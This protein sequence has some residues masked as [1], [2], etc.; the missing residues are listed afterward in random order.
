[1]SNLKT[2]TRST[3]SAKEGSNT[4]NTR[5]TSNTN[6]TSN[7]S[8]TSNTNNTNNTKDD[9]LVVP[10]PSSPSI[11]PKRK[12][13]NVT[14]GSTMMTTGT[15]RR[16]SIST[17][18]TPSTMMR[19]ASTSN[20]TMTS[21]GGKILTPKDLTAIVFT[22]LNDRKSH[23]KNQTTRMTLSDEEIIDLQSTLY[24]KNKKGGHSAEGDY[25]HVGVEEEWLLNQIEGLNNKDDDAERRRIEFKRKM[26]TMRRGVRIGEY[27]R[28]EGGGGGGDD[29]EEEVMTFKQCMTV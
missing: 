4:S 6:N 29:D 15:G 24:N 20:G 25:G 1:L 11:R 2:T 13:S 26:R 5:N 28:M 18:M 12:S 27:R 10:D 3:H 19:G 23:A 22:P 9:I 17:P 21:N 7:T 16:M 14:G 8:N